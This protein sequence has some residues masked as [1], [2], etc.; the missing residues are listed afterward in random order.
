[1][2]EPY[3]DRRMLK[4]LPF[5]S[6]PEQGGDLADVFK[7]A[8]PDMPELSEDDYSLMQYRFEEAFV[9]KRQVCITFFRSGRKVQEHGQILGFD[10]FHK[11]IIMTNESVHVSDII[12]LEICC[13]VG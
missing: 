7:T 8:P 6:L 3:V 10:P 2:A 12:A 5:Q 1:M 4:W 13:D 9:A 11:T